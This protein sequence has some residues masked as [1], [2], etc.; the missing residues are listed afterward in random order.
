MS[1]SPKPPKARRLH[2]NTI[3]S[4]VFQKL[5][6]EP[7]KGTKLG[8]IGPS[9]GTGLR[10]IVRRIRQ[11]GSHKGGTANYGKWDEV[12]YMYGDERR[13]VRKAI[14]LNE[15]YI[16]A[17]FNSGGIHRI[18]QNWGDGMYNILCQEWQYHIQNRDND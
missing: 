11:P 13:A 14:E 9:T 18:P 16:E 12:V 15:E 7:R 5:K 10:D 1:D 17:L 4:H 8:K 6:K 3:S 2:H